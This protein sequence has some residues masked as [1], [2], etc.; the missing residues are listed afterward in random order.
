MADI[1]KIELPDGTECELKDAVVRANLAEAF[2]ITRTIST[3]QTTSLSFT[4]GTAVAGVIFVGGASNNRRGA[5]SY[6]ATA[7]GNVGVTDFHSCSEIVHSQD[8]RTIVFENT[9]AGTA[10]ML[11]IQYRGGKDVV[12]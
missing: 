6:G 7:N 10:Y 4:S 5:Y 3:G 11:V 9:G 8:G 1:S 2:M 12:R